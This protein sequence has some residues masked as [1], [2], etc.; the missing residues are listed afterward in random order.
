MCDE[1]GREYTE[2][3]LRRALDVFA[4]A[5][6]QALTEALREAQTAYVRVVTGPPLPELLVDESADV[7][8]AR[9]GGCGVF[10]QNMNNEERAFA[11]LLDADTTGRVKWWLRLQESAS[12][13]PTLILP[14]GRVSFRI[15]PSA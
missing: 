11:E 7:R 5:R 6:P 9:L 10:P 1:Q 8:P 15:S 3:D 4:M 12:W 13:A 2:Q 14:S